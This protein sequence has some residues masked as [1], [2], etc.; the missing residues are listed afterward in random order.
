MKDTDNFRG[1]YSKA[2]AELDAHRLGEAVP[3]LHELVDSI[4]SWQL[5]DELENLNSS[6]LLL[7]D[8][9]QKG[10]S[11][12]EREKQ[13]LSFIASAYAIADK[14]SNIVRA[15]KSGISARSLPSVLKDLEDIGMKGIT[16]ALSDSD[17]QSHERLDA[18]IF[19]ASEMSGIW[20]ED[21]FQ[22]ACDVRNSALLTEDDKIMMISG[23][24]L[25]CLYLFDP[26]K[27]K[28]L[29]EWYS[30]GESMRIRVLLLIAFVFSIM[31]YSRRLYAY[32]WMQEIFSVLDGL[33]Y[34]REDIVSL[35]ILTLET[36]ST[37][38]VNRKLSEEIIPSMLK[39]K[40]LNLMRFDVGNLEDL[41]SANPEWKDLE[42]SM[43]KL[44]EL[45]ARGADV[46]YSTFSQL[47]KYPFF[48]E[49]ANWFRPFD[50]QYSAL[51]ENIRSG[52]IH[53]IMSALL[54]SEAIPDSDK[55][56]FCFLSAMMDDRQR[57]MLSSA[58]PGEIPQN[59]NADKREVCLRNYLRNMFRYFNLW[60]GQH[61]DDPFTGDVSFIGN[62]L[63]R[64]PLS[65]SECIGRI[66]SYAVETKNYTVALAYL[67]RYDGNS[68]RN[69]SVFQK[70]GF[71][72]QRTGRLSEAVTQYETALAYDPD[73]KWT[74]RRLAHINSFMGNSA[75]ALKYYTRLEDTGVKDPGIS[76]RKGECLAR[77]K[78]YKEAMNEFYK[79]EYLEGGENAVRAIAWCAV[80]MDDLSTA[81]KYYGKLVAGSGC[82]AGDLIQAG[83]VAWAGGNIRAASELYVSAYKKMANESFAGKFFADNAVLTAH[84]ISK[85]DIILMYDFI[86]LK[87]S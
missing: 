30:E 40:D 58:I 62:P 87:R 64:A 39:S 73:S 5:L 80:R 71:C 15:G 49:E 65:G 20:N 52:N 19:N 1:L 25:N 82:N 53:G 38:E 7:L 76:I 36:I 48:S 32:P 85:E 45:E 42:N 13:H 27:I 11:D 21:A 4:G 37:H 67:E 50:S 74:L 51:P 9:M 78:K 24:A 16:D 54:G 43:G 61:P 23:L 12:P 70:Y 75:E 14:A 17:R 41:Q 31:K 86:I 34:Y 83:H 26:M 69:A 81:G 3:L 63:L 46:Y 44:A 79:A 84:G 33:T 35:Q 10:L 59:E 60:T 55:F 72:L 22:E 77:E 18:E 2:I 29:T 56:S 66:S 47:K 28:F 6:Y 8:Y 68:G 57:E